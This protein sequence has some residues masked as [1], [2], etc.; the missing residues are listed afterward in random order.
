MNR[1]TPLHNNHRCYQR[2]GAASSAL[3]PKKKPDRAR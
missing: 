2:L 3:W 1:Y